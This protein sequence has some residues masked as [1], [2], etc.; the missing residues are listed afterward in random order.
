MP[1]R[2]GRIDDPR[3]KSDR[4]A[5]FH[6]PLEGP[7]SRQE[8]NEERER[9]SPTA[10]SSVRGNEMEGTVPS[11][12]RY[13]VQNSILVG[14]DEPK[15]F[16]PVSRVQEVDHVLESGAWATIG[17]VHQE[18]QGGDKSCRGFLRCAGLRTAPGEEPS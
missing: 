17:I 9:G 12:W 4:E 16:N 8:S 14:L 6:D 18:V 3:R 13:G 5:E 10:H 1:S 7:S 2:E 11:G 15:K